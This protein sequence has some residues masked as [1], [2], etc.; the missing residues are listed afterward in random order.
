[1][2]NHHHQPKSNR[3]YSDFFTSGFRAMASRASRRMTPG[4]APTPSID[5]TLTTDRS[6]ASTTSTSSSTR[7]RRTSFRNITNR[8]S[9]T[10]SM[11][12]P[13]MS[14]NMNINAHSEYTG[15]ATPPRDRRSSIASFS[16]W[17][18]DR[19]SSNIDNSFTFSPSPQ[20][21]SRELHRSTEITEVWITAGG[22]YTPSTMSRDTDESGLFQTIDPFASSPE[23]K[24]FFIDLSES[25]TPTPPSGAHP[26]LPAH[27]HT[28][29]KR[30][31]FLSFTPSPDHSFLHLP[32]PRRER[33][34]S[35]QTMP[36]PSRSRRS[37]YYRPPSRGK[38]DHSWTLPEEHLPQDKSQGSARRRSQASRRESLAEDSEWVDPT[39]DVDWRQFHIELLG[40]EA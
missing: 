26:H 16:S 11:I 24:S 5:T 1:M 17:L 12:G 10:T 6:T 2:S 4:P 29:A 21:N 22:P 3:S 36:L 34:T 18:F 7:A 27:T 14:M 25:P 28:H 13:S 20:K 32:R 23:S 33:P 31:S 38:S 8:H 40:V 9:R 15:K 35:V 37:S 19:K 30:E 39:R